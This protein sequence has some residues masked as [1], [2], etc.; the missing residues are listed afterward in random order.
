MS[1]MS[2][3]NLSWV[4]GGLVGPTL[5]CQRTDRD[6]DLLVRVVRSDTDAPLDGL[7]VRLT[8]Q[9][10]QN[11]GT[12]GTGTAYFTALRKGIHAVQVN[13]LTPDHLATLV[14]PAA[15]NVTMARHKRKTVVIR[16]DVVPLLTLTFC[17]HHFAPSREVVTVGY[18]IRGL[19]HR[20][21]RLT[22]SSPQ[23]AN[24]LLFERVLTA[25]EKTDGDHTITWDGR[26]NRGAPMKNRYV[27]PLLAPYTV[28]IVCP[29]AP[30]GG[31][32]THQLHVYYHSIQIRQGTYTPDGQP[33]VKVTHPVAWA[34]YRLNEL[35]YFAGPV[36]NVKGPQTQ[37]ALKRYSYASPGFYPTVLV[38]DSI[39]P[40][41]GGNRA[42]FTRAAG[43]TNVQ[44]G[45]VIHVAAGPN[46]GTD[47]QV[48][49]INGA[50]TSAT[51]VGP[52][53]AL[54]DVGPA[55]NTSVALIE[56]DDEA[57]VTLDAQLTAGDRP[58]LVFE[59][60]RLPAAGEQ[61]K[62]YL[63]HDYFYGTT[64]N[65][66]DPIGHLRQ[67]E[68]KL[69]PIEVP[70]EAS[71][72]LV[73]RDDADGSGRGI[74]VDPEAIGPVEIEWLVDDLPEDL[75]VLPAAPTPAVPS[76][77]RIYMTTHALP[78]LQDAVTGADNCPA[79]NNAGGPGG[80]RR[81]AA[82]DH[83]PSFA[84][85]AQHLPWTT[86]HVGT[87]V[88]STMHQDPVLHP[89]KRGRAGAWF[90]G[91][92]IAGDNFRITARIAFNRHGANP[93]L[94]ANHQTLANLTMRALTTITEASTGTFTL[95][96]THHIAA[97]VHWPAPTSMGG[98]RARAVP[99]DTIAA[100]Y[101]AAH[102]ELRTDHATYGIADLLPTVP[103]QASYLQRIDAQMLA[104]GYGPPG[105]NAEFRA[106]GIVPFSL[107]PQGNLR[108][109]A[110]DNLL[111]N[112]ILP[113]T[114]AGGVLDQIGA[115]L[116]EKVRERTGAGT[117]LLRFDWHRPIFIRPAVRIVGRALN[118]DWPRYFTT[119]NACFGGMC[120]VAFL[121]NPMSAA[122]G[123][124]LF[125]HEMAHC[126]FLRHHE[127]N[128]PLGGSDNPTDHDLNDHNCVMSYPNGIASRNPPLAPAT[129]VWS[130]GGAEQP[131][132]CGKCLLKLRGWNPTDPA[133]PV[134]S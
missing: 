23:Y 132:F 80:G 81:P 14:A 87:S 99:F 6:P 5:P 24:V 52:G 107:P 49:R 91:S 35:G 32:A 44:I 119:T 41:G 77:G 22:V 70:V 123:P 69:D 85:G 7:E 117:I 93:N 13:R 76:R 34:Q 27:H 127:T 112:A 2:S 118:V 39:A 46:N 98:M 79:A 103:D 38:L 83:G 50:A 66:L 45:D 64:D 75:T 47:W 104:G 130:E 18:R 59:D 121:E 37:R 54:A 30:N 82:T 33:P 131:G 84:I 65:F 62:A 96:R 106:D 113:F 97:V 95:W 101:R 55:I 19:S 20:A 10:A 4:T 8:P 58:R 134:Q 90:R 126:R 73:S 68:Q 43:L 26:A 63:S 74:E 92:Y 16:V 109:A 3:A 9:L 94:Q 129:L 100:Q 114:G 110:Y 36:D 67:D 89:T 105:S 48:L 60:D 17:D 124:Y 21:V 12:T 133:L 53:A 120:G 57:H 40:A 78:A 116:Y 51:V 42:T 31:T 86:A 15:R 71:L 108:A 56:T 1:F 128:I 11:S 102:C 25:G 111:G 28:Q 61:V 115:V 125:A 29:Q 72:L 122:E 88:Y